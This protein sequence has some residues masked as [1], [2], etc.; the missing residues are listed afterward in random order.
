MR[1]Y[2]LALYY[3]LS[4]NLSLT[5]VLIGVAIMGFAFAVI[6]QLA[7]MFRDYDN[8]GVL[9]GMVGV[10]GASLVLLGGTSYLFF[11]GSKLFARISEA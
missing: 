3:V 8:W 6:P 1:V 4:G 2:L 10:W 7:E 11:L 5:T 9:E